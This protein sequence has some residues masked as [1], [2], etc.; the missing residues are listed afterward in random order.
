MIAEKLCKILEKPVCDHCLGRQFAQLLHGYDNKERGR[1]LR[2]V[3]AMFVD[4]T[5]YENRMYMSNFHAFRFHNIKNAAVKNKKCDVCGGIF[6]ETEKWSE[7][8]VRKKPDFRTF[9]V[10]T[11]LSSEL[12]R[13]EEEMWERVGID[14][15]E[16]IKA[17]INRE[18]GKII[19][20]KGYAFDPKRPDVNLIID[21]SKR[22]IK[23]EVNPIFIYGEY[24]KLVRGIP[25]TKWPSG[26]YKTSVEQIIAKPFM[27]ATSG[28]GHK[29]HG[30]G[31]EDIN[32]RCLGWRP[33]V[34][35][36]L[37]PKKRA[38]DIKKTAKKIPGKVRVRNLRLSNIEEVRRIKEERRDKTYHAVVRCEHITRKD[39]KKLSVIK[40]LRQ[41][42]PTRVSHRRADLWRTRTV[43][44]IKASYINK[45]TFVIEV[46]TEAGLYIKELI[47][48]DNGRTNPSIS[49]VLGQPCTCKELDVIRIHTKK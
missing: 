44:H 29:L 47:S 46:R 42:T 23:I 36:I 27:K 8:A 26:K 1:I 22:K 16:P 45:K 28:S 32:A 24:Q 33:F 30:C 20:K 5:E 18:A 25:Q 49:S 21:V 34:L 12:I 19:E 31:R 2:T 14:Y 39:L 13:K 40:E 43:R 4:I 35:E 41:R 7:R 15:C 3:A 38:I 9:L 11:K 48:G 17:E 10:G 6:R 37:Q